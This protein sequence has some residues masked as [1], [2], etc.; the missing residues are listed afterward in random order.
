MPKKVETQR[1]NQVTS[2][3]GYVDGEKVFA[4]AV[5]IRYIERKETGTA[6]NAAA[7]SER[8][9]STFLARIGKGKEWLRKNAP[10]GV[11]FFHRNELFSVMAE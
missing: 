11:L 7:M 2:V 4:T 6:V 1:A 3:T 5:P 8:V 9:L 10:G